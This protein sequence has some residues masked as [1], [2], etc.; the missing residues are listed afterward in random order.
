MSYS[1][2]HPFTGKGLILLV[3]QMPT[4]I[5][6]AAIFLFLCNEKYQWCPLL[7]WEKA[8]RSPVSLH[9][10]LHHFNVGEP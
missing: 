5:Y 4:S 1:C 2:I 9:T 3:A 8:E 6:D 10:F 7:S